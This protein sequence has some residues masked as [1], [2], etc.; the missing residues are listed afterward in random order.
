MGRREHREVLIRA[1]VVAVRARLLHNP[2][3]D[4]VWSALLP[5]YAQAEISHGLVH[6][7]LGE[8]IPHANRLPDLGSGALA[9][10]SELNWMAIGL[11]PRVVAA[12]PP[13]SLWSPWASMLD[14]VALLRSV[15]SGERIAVLLAES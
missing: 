8:P 3:A 1:G 12:A 4:R 6:F 13:G 11:A 5:I 9:Y 2:V 14:D 7:S 15:G 10:S